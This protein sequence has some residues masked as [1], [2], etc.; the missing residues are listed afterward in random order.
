MTNEL[1]WVIGVVAVVAILFIALAWSYGASSG[2]GG[3]GS[4]PDTATAADP[5]LL[6]RPDSQE[7]TAA[8][9]PVTLVEFGDY[10][11]PACGAAYPIVKAALAKYAGKVNFVF[12]NFPL[13]QHQYAVV[14][15]EAAEIAGDQG[16]FWEMHDAL[17]ERQDA[18]TTSSDPKS[19]FASY[20]TELG[21][22]ASQFSASLDAGKYGD[23]VKR[24]QADG[25]ALGVNQTPTFY[26]N[27]RELI[28]RSANDLDAAIA[29]ALDSSDASSTQA[30][31]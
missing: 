22:D 5:S 31:Q 1:K 8:G 7:S 10:Q 13:P 9:A 27:G 15:A 2:T 16:K 24:D 28:L 20:A 3:A 30:Q 25:N 29:A 14:A 19:L 17:Y 21:M 12:R 4:R 11:C 18:W 26:V 23:K 6:I